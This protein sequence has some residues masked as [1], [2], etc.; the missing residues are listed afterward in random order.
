MSK[1]A[2]KEPKKEKRTERVV[3]RAT[4]KTRRTWS[5]L[6]FTFTGRKD[7][8]YNNAEELFTAMIDAFKKGLRP[9][10]RYR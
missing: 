6:V 9:V 1:E 5:K 10:P 7:K 8:K 2:L 3:I 4:P